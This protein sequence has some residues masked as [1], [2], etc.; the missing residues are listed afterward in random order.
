MTEA[1]ERRLRTRVTDAPED[2]TS[3]D[4]AGVHEP[5]T[6]TASSR[7]RVVH[8]TPPVEA[9]RVDA[10]VVDPFARRRATVH[11]LIQAI[12]L[13]F[14]IVEALIALRF[15]LKALAANPASPFAGFLYGVTAPLVAPFVGLFATPTF[16]GSVIELHSIVALVVYALLAWAI[17]KL[18]WL[19]FGET[20]H[21]VRTSATTVDTDLR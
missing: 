1:D 20:R 9:E 2:G 11:K 10:V 6:D 12:S 4:R 15:I 16:G 17:C 3:S 21:A 7:P 5:P 13:L 14:G 8:T 18:V 19:L